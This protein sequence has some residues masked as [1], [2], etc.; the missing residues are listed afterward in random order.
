M[1]FPEYS[2]FIE[3]AKQGNFVPVYMELVADLDT[4]VSAWYRVCQGQPYSFLLES[5]EGGERLGRYSLLGC[6]PLWVLEARGDRTTQTFRDGKVKEFFGNPFQHLNNCLAS[7][8]P[9][10]L[11]ELPPSLGGLFGYWGYELINWIEP[12]VPV[13]PCQ[14]GDTP[15]GVWM[16]VD[17][18]LVF[19]QV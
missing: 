2:D 13:Y 6:A 5:V 19:D 1:I 4:P 16:Q 9:V 7:I 14:E 12:K 11:P 8:K 10:H 18:L 3:L 15:D 17:S